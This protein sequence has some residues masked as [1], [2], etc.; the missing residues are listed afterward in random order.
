MQRPNVFL[1]VSS[2]LI[3]LFARRGGG[4]GGGELEGAAQWNRSGISAGG[5]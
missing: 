2:F 3:S 5:S 1:F 4:V